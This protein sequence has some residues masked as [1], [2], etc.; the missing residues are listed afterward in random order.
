MKSL[1]NKIKKHLKKLSK[2]YNIDSN[3]L[4]FLFSILV[5]LFI[6]YEIFK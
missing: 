1:I 6:T 5:I 2:E 3:V 4:V